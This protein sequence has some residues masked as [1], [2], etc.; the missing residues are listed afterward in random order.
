MQK[1]QSAL[2]APSKSGRSR[3]MG[4]TKRLL[5][6]DDSRWHKTGNDPVSKII[7]T[8]P[9]TST[10]VFILTS[11]FATTVFLLS[12]VVTINVAGRT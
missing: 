8:G 7:K 3:G 1:T 12:P 10:G 9:S 4:P 11:V 2:T 6:R 5:I